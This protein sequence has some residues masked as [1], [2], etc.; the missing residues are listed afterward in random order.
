MMG[1][2]RL[3]TL[4]AL[5]LLL[6]LFFPIAGTSLAAQSGKSGITSASTSMANA[7]RITNAD[8]K[9]AAKRLA[10]AKAKGGGLLGARS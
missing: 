3:L 8:R 4:A 1:T 10:A 6:A 5:L 9:A 2:R 7:K